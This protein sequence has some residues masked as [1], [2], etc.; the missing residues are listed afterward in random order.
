VSECPQLLA[1]DGARQ[2]GTRREAE[3]S[4]SPSW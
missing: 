4:G 3:R 1:D 2:T